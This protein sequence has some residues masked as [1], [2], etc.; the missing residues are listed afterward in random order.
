MEIQSKNT[1]VGAK[2]LQRWVRNLLNKM[3]YFP[4]CCAQSPSHVQLFATP[5]TVAH[6]APLWNSS[7]RNPGVG[8]HFLLQ[9]VFLTQGLNLCP[10]HL[11]DWQADYQCATWGLY[12]FSESGGQSGFCLE[13]WPLRF[14]CVGCC[15][16]H[17]LTAGTYKH[18]SLEFSEASVTADHSHRQQSLTLLGFSAPH[19][20]CSPAD[21]SSPQKTSLGH[22]LAPYTNIN[23]KWL[24]DLHVRPDTIK[25]L[26]ENTG[27]TF[28]DM[29]QQCFLRSVSQGKGSKSKSKQMGSN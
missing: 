4:V 23:S 6:Q 27:Q 24:N 12:I 26:E 8:C 22:S 1:H 5:W 25:L 29:S 14:G 11:L 16:P 7:G 19:R 10:L 3:C 20:Y 21:C 15:D 28:S 13:P 17:V 9:G 2:A 18:I